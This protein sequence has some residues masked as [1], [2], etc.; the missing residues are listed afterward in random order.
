MRHTFGR[1]LDQLQSGRSLF[2]TAIIILL[3]LCIILYLIG[4]WWSREPELL[5]V[6]K[7]AE[8]HAAQA[9]QSVVVGYTTTVT[10]GTVAKTL[11]EKPGGYLTNDVIPPSIF[12]DNM[13]NWEFGAFSVTRLPLHSLGGLL[14][15][16]DPRRIM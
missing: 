5:A 15:L 8:A 12:L 16:N 3:S 9:G 6:Q 2:R 13:P 14:S 10:L 1:F 11:L 4:W 7:V